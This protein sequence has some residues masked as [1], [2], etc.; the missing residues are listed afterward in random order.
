LRM[1]LE[2]GCAGGVVSLLWCRFA[3]PNIPKKIK[4]R[5]NGHCVF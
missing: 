2:G 1:L 3:I 4:K 5:V